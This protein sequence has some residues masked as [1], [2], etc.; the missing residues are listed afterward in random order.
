MNIFHLPFAT[1]IVALA[2]AA[3]SSANWRLIVID[4]SSSMASGSR[5]QDV[6]REISTHLINQPPTAVSPVT[7]LTFDTQVRD[8][9]RFTKMADALHYVDKLAADGRGTSIAA[10][11]TGALAELQKQSQVDGIAVMLF[12][13]DQDPDRTAIQQAENELAK[14]FH[15]RSER[16]LTQAVL[17]RRWSS[18]GGLDTLVKRLQAN[19]NV[20]VLSSTTA[21]EFTPI[22]VLPA[23]SVERAE[24]T[25]DDTVNV[26]FRLSTKIEGLPAGYDPP[27]VEF[28]VENT[29][30]GAKRAWSVDG[31][32]ASVAAE[33]LLKLSSSQLSTGK[34]VLALLVSSKKKPATI[35]KQVLAVFPTRR[36]EVPIHFNARVKHEF[37]VKV[38]PTGKVRW[39][40]KQGG[41][42]IYDCRLAAL[43]RRVGCQKKCG[44]PLVPVTIEWSAASPA[45]FASGANSLTLDSP[46]KKIVSFSVAIPAP[47]DR[48]DVS[49]TP[50]A[51]TMAVRI[52]KFPS[53]AVFRL[54]KRTV[55][56]E[57]LPRPKANSRITVQ[58]LSP[59]GARWWRPPNIAYFAA[60]MRVEIDGPFPEDS[61]ILFVSSGVQ[62]FKVLPKKLLTGS[63]EAELRIAMPLPITRAAKPLTIALQPPITTE[64]IA[65]DCPK[66]IKVTLPELPR[67]ILEFSSGSNNLNL[68]VWPDATRAQS[69]VTLVVTG[70]VSKGFRS[71]L[72]LQVG[73]QQGQVSP[74]IG[75]GGDFTL[76]MG[77]NLSAPSHYFGSET[78]KVPFQVSAVG[79]GSV[80]VPITGEVVVV[81]Y[82]KFAQHMVYFLGFG[83]IV[84]AIGSGWWVFRQIG[85]DK[86]T[87]WNDESDEEPAWSEEDLEE[88]SVD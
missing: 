26:R 65:Y 30:V 33:T 7:F 19:P 8:V 64:S 16:G 72:Q 4:N 10:G 34:S 12:T 70:P 80:V 74:F 82:G 83:A 88:E 76:P 38:K 41:Q 71:R 56:C 5:I 79:D 52:T 20:Q 40:A 2:L 37:L 17:I 24:L 59:V 27:R 32:G 69:K 13:D 78:M 66:E 47:N 45:V 49:Q 31:K 29:A 68:Y 57:G 36:I 14:L 3:E 46:T 25:K 44:K 18:G 9:Q 62:Q 85:G 35:G 1:L 86:K 28:V 53:R 48:L 54:K 67:P 43:V 11:L 39:D 75:K 6:Q 51:F 22:R 63:N 21:T 77:I 58:P 42:W 55:R 15:N 73:D 61:E 81:R 84:S 87:L 23:I 60:P 50:K